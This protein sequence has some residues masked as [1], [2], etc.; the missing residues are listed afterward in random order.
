MKL[1]LASAVTFTKKSSAVLIFLAALG[2]LLTLAFTLWGPMDGGT[3]NFFD[4][5]YDAVAL[6][7]TGF[8]EW[9]ALF[10]GVTLA[11]LFAGI[12]MLAALAFAAF[13]CAAAL[14]FTAG[15]LVFTAII[16]LS[17][18]VAVVGLGWLA[19]YALRRH[20]ERATERASVVA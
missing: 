7:E 15:V 5:E 1:T 9:M 8:I 18:V 17:P 20:R 13:V 3:F 10:V 2:A 4:A 19:V 12:V 6:A 16:V 11:Y 14:L